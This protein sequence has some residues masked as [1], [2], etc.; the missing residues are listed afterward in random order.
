MD[1]VNEQA[2][3]KRYESIAEKEFQQKIEEEINKLE[4]QKESELSE[5]DQ[6]YKGQKKRT[7]ENLNKKWYK[8]QLFS[9]VLVTLVVFFVNFFLYM[10][11]YASFFEVIAYLSPVFG[12]V[13]DILFFWPKR[14]S[15]EN[16]N[17]LNVQYDRERAN[18][19]VKYQEQCEKVRKGETPELRKMRDEIFGMAERNAEEEI[20]KLMKTAD[21]FNTQE[22]S[23]V[24]IKEDENEKEALRFRDRLLLSSVSFEPIIDDAMARLSRC[25]DSLKPDPDKEFYDILFSFDVK[26]S[27]IYYNSP[28]DGNERQAPG[29][30]LF[31]FYEHRYQDLGEDAQ[32]EGFAMVLQ[33]YIDERIPDVFSDMDVR[34]NWERKKDWVRLRIQ[35]LNPDFCQLQSWN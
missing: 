26:T 6:N 1:V 22:K 24:V 28:K 14:R 4:K 29:G 16:E 10:I 18:V 5:F 11:T 15:N 32:R 13:C 12:V 23:P 33:Q 30:Y 27:G 34:K 3:R 7:D 17:R 2:I 8:P 19:I 35:Y 31:S 25:R 20:T 21:D 9:I